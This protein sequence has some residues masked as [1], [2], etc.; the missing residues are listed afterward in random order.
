M[1]QHELLLLPLLPPCTAATVLR[2]GGGMWVP[3]KAAYT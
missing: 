2:E 1:R 3:K